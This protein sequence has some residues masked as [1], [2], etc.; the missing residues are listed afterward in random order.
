M[1][2]WDKATTYWVYVA[3]AVLGVVGFIQNKGAEHL[4][5]GD[6]VGHKILGEKGRFFRGSLAWIL[7]G[8]VLF[9][10]TLW[11]VATSNLTWPFLRKLGM[12]TPIGG[13][14]MIAGFSIT[15]YRIWK[16]NR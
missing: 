8:A 16:M 3:L 7:L 10:G 9:S 15:G 5:D 1:H 12:I 4:V 2:T 6:E 14:L 13:V 11:L